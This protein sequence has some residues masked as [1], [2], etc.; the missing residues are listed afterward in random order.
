MTVSPPCRYFT[1]MSI[2]NKL[3]VHPS[4]QGR[5]HATFMLQWGLRLSDMDKVDQGVI[6]SHVGEPL[7]LGLGYKVIGEMHVPSDGEVDGFSQRVVKY[8]AKR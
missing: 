4:Y 6:P 3:V 2:C 5:G 7:Y 1:G 8:K